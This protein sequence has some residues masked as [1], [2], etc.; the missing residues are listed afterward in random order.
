[1]SLMQ[2]TMDDVEVKTGEDGTIVLMRRALRRE[3]T[4]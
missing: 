2:A 3:E 1:M 4:S